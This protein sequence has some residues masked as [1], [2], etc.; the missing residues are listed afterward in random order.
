MVQGDGSQIKETLSEYLRVNPNVLMPRVSWALEA[1]HL[2]RAET[3]SLKAWYQLEATPALPSAELASRAADVARAQREAFD[4]AEAGPRRLVRARGDELVAATSEVF[5]DLGFATDFASPKGSGDASREDLQLR[6]SD[7]N[8]S[9]ALVMTCGHDA[10]AEL[11]V[12]DE[13]RRLALTYPARQHGAGHVRLWYVANQYLGNGPTPPVT[14]RTAPMR[15]RPL[16]LEA[17]EVERFTNVGG[18]II[19]SEKLLA[20]ALRVERG[21]WRLVA[22][23]KSC[24]VRWGGFSYRRLRG[25]AEHRGS[26]YQPR[27]ISLTRGRSRHQSGGSES[28]R[29]STQPRSEW[30]VLSVW[31]HACGSVVTVRVAVNQQICLARSQPARTVAALPRRAPRGSRW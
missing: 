3:S 25:T 19:A 2:T 8:D 27:S 24:G 23:G 20:L 17:D 14:L 6:Q 10:G 7:S 9:L 18:L 21:E 30:L 13:L 11:T 31:R 5:R 29:V 26:Y 1:R 12:I 22:L 28:P 15:A 4:A 16:G